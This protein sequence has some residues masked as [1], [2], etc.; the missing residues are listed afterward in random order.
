MVVSSEARAEVDSP[1][2]AGPVNALNAL[3]ARSYGSCD[4]VGTRCK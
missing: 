4:W 2:A 3:N 1:E